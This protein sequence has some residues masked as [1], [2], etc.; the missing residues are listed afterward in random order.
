MFEGYSLWST[1]TLLAVM[2]EVEV[3]VSNYWRSLCFPNVMTSTDEYIDL[4]KIPAAGRKLAPFVAPMAQGR[5]IFEEGTR[6]A[7]FKPSYVKAL[8]PVTPGRALTRRPGSI[9]SQGPLNP[10]AN[11]DAIK[12]DILAYH[13]TAVERVHE[14]L[15][16]KA[17]IEGKVT[18]QGDDM[19]ARL[20]DF[21][22]AAG[23]DVINASGTRWG[24]SGVSIIDSV[25]ADMTTMHDAAFG[26]A[27]TR[28]TIG[29]AA[30]A[31]LRKSP[32]FK[33]LMDLN[34]RG[35]DVDI[36]RGILQ[37][38]E[39][40]YV[41]NLGRTG[42]DIYVY[43]DWYQNAGQ[44]VPFM[45]PRDVVYTSPNVQGYQCFGAIQDVYAGFQAI[46]VFPRNWI[47]IGDPAVEHLLTQSA[48]LMVPVNPNATMRRRV[49]G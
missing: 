21:Q 31:V 47:N 13:R 46:P 30:W 33:D 19:P 15:A 35:S 32:E 14:W 26:G 39:V 5:P 20:V 18:I 49:V 1:H 44:R 17:I 28:M 4:E 40:R 25:E 9:L 29:T 7:R 37:P 38:G 2:R 42:L 34:F 48:P 41:G 6:V 27:P 10:Q 3:P 45:D 16:A 23:Q 22:R 36:V 8:D 11:Y 24:D 12:T 43:N